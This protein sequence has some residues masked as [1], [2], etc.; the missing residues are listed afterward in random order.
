ML[1]ASFPAKLGDFGLARLVDH[2]RGSHTTVLAGTMGY[3]DPECMINSRANAESDVYSFGVVLLDIACGQRPLVRRHEEEDVIHIV[4][5]VWEWHGRGAIVDAAD[6]RLK[7]EFDAREMETVMVVGLCCAHPDRSLRPSIRQAV[8]VLRSEVPLPNLPARMPVATYEPLNGFYYTS[9]VVTGGSSSTDSGTTQSSMTIATVLPKWP[10]I[11]RDCKDNKFTMPRDLWSPSQATRMPPVV[12][13][14][15]RYSKTVY[16]LPRNSAAMKLST[17]SLL[18][19][20]FQHKSFKS[21]SNGS[22][23]A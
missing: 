17:V 14:A 5:W 22:S 19:A 13:F 15:A 9:S 21:Q 11:I 20:Q 7:G 1:D 16:N 2:G 6:A 23:R 4:Q 10:Q 8:S 18:A 3:M 12:P